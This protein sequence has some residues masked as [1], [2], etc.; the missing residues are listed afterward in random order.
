MGNWVM[1][2]ERIARARRLGILPM[3]NP[4]FL[5]FFGDPSVE[6]LGPR[7]TQQGFPFQSMWQAGIPISFGSDAPGYFPVDPLRDLGAAAAHGTLS[8]ATINRA[9]ALSM[10]QALRCQTANAA[11]T[12]FVENTLGSIE[13]GKLA[14]IA[15]FGDDPFTFDP[16]R[17]R[18]LPVD[19]TISGGR[20]VYD[21]AAAGS[22][23]NRPANLT[24]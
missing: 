5:Y 4:S 18:E 19:I 3:S 11:F 7:M 9:E 10:S 1:T 12:G 17:F 21:R 15:V 8:G 6:M 14:D 13:P 22:R 16:A 24:G 20:V 2:P 23:E